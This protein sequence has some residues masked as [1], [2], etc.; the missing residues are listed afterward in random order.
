MQDGLVFFPFFSFFC[1]VLSDLGKESPGRIDPQRRFVYRS[2]ELRWKQPFI[3]LGQFNWHP[4]RRES[5]GKM[6]RK[7]T[8]PR[9]WKGRTSSPIETAELI[10]T[11][12]IAAAIFRRGCKSVCVCAYS[13]PT[14]NQEALV[15]LCRCACIWTKNT[16]K[17]IQKPVCETARSL[18]FFEDKTIF[19]FLRKDPLARN[20]YINIR[21]GLF[22]CIRA[23]GNT[24][25]ECVR[26][27]KNSP[28]NIW[29]LYGKWFLRTIF[30]YSREC[31]SAKTLV[32]QTLHQ[33]CRA[34]AVALHL[35]SIFGL[36]F[37]QCRTTVALHPWKGLKK[38]TVAAASVLLGGC[39]TS[40]WP[41]LYH[42]MVS[43]YS[44]CSSYSV[45]LSR[46]TATLRRKQALHA[47]AQKLIP[48]EFLSACIGFVP[49]G[50]FLIQMV[51][52]AASSK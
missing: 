44:A 1:F 45:A 4:T 48:E 31:T 42:K 52:P 35:C 25:A 11:S 21:Q 23:A 8:W 17:I 46:Y 39:S 51:L 15:F 33:G 3:E 34:T 27:E 10:R 36:V 7:W 12:S 9:V 16:N 20:Q 13:T 41:C 5:P 22:S 28:K 50:I 29:Q 26:T 47:F 19:H 18:I 2:S 6:E 32:A 24:G 30:L 40:S 43:R 37:S 38:G 14:S 49:G